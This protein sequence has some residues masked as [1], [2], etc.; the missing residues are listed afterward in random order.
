MFHKSMSWTRLTTPTYVV[1]LHDCR[2]STFISTHYIL[3][4]HLL[5]P[6]SKLTVL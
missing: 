1:T 3:D 2:N 6:H 5:F 4:F